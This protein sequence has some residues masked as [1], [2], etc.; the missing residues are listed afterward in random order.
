M[1]NYIMLV[2][3]KLNCAK[4]KSLLTKNFSTKLKVRHSPFICN[5]EVKLGFIF[6][7]TSGQCHLFWCTDIEHR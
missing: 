4:T 3:I 2:I 5:R 6:Y 1:W 7:S